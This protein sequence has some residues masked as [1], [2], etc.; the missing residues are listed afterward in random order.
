MVYAVHVLRVMS[1]KRYNPVQVR[2]SVMRY[3]S[4]GIFTAEEGILLGV[5]V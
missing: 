1:I 4:R 5:V 3:G 2:P